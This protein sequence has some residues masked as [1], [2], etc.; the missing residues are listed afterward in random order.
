MANF[1]PEFYILHM[2]LGVSEDSA[3]M[4]VTEATKTGPAV[5]SFLGQI[6][7]ISTNIGQLEDLLPEMPLL[8]LFGFKILV[9]ELASV[10]FPL[11]RCFCP[12][13]ST[14]ITSISVW[15]G[16]LSWIWLIQNATAVLKAVMSFSLVFRF[17][18]IGSHRLTSC[19]WPS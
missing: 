6:Y 16:D 2:S 14:S 12:R 13:T 10:N 4:F 18:P 9:T 8:L 17:L 1:T 5:I 3:S 11:G 19:A 15:I 7:Q